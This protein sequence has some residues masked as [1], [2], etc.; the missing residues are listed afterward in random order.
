MKNIDEKTG[1]F[2]ACGFQKSSPTEL[3]SD[4]KALNFVLM[5][6]DA[7]KL[8]VAVDECIRKL[9]SYN[10]AKTSGKNAGLMMVVHLDTKRIRI[11]EG[12]L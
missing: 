2:G 8:N 1:S 6:E 5:F 9:N 3:S 4:T 7:L 10:R 12:K 11:L